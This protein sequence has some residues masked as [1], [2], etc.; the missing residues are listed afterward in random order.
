MKILKMKNFIVPVLFLFLYVNVAAQQR[1]LAYYLENAKNNSPLVNKTRNENKLADL[2]LEQIRS[3]LSKPEINLESAVLFAPI[4]S[5]DNGTNAFQ[6][7]SGGANDYTGY[8][9]AST[10]GGQYLAVVSLKQPLFNGS[11][12]STYSNKAEISKKLND[13]NIA[14]TL[15]E[16]EQIVSYQYILCLKSKLEIEN[17]LFLI[18]EV[19]EQLVL[20]KKLVENAIYRQKDLLLLQIEYQNNVA[21]NKSLK[22]EYRNNIYDLNLLCGISDT[23][24]VDIQSIELKL[25]PELAS[26]SQFRTS[27]SL[28]SM[29]ILADQAINDLKY[30][31]QAD[32]F[33]NAGMNAVYLPAFNRLGFSTGITLSWNIFDGNQ[34][35]IQN[36]KSTINIQTLEFEK[37]KFLT[38]KDINRNKLFDQINLLDQR[39]ILTENQITQYEYLYNVYKKELSLGEI[40]VMDYKNLLKDAAAKKHENVMLKM[41]K[42]VLINSY[43]YWNY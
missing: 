42:Q 8:D 14:L 37:T 34:R 15:H 31:I 33:A 5:H 2:D 1:D 43:N 32:L 40:S 30:K 38:Q 41:E 23:S 22:S 4:I 35:K 21:N 24:L 10:D 6:F 17:S 11:K 9:Q 27:Y 36:E 13:N 18:K 7:V 19:D 39:I 16:I 25:N 20:M 12:F 26:K 28:D 3:I 29:N